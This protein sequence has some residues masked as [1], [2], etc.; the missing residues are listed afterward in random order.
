M[1]PIDRLAPSTHWR[2][3]S[4]V[5][6]NTIW[7]QIDW[8]PVIRRMFRNSYCRRTNNNPRRLVRNIISSDLF[9]KI[10]SMDFV[11][12][13]CWPPRKSWVYSIL[14][15]CM[16]HASI[17]NKYEFFNRNWKI[18]SGEV[19]AD[20]F[21]KCSTIRVGCDFPGDGRPG[22]FKL[23]PKNTLIRWFSK[24]FLPF[25]RYE[26]ASAISCH[27]HWTCEIFALM[28]KMHWM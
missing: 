22:I 23:S 16:Y 2:S 13:A 3:Y 15:I 19:E 26:N 5:T 20:V 17:I 25:V 12:Q 10:I 1:F 14:L 9:E 27:N 28:S 4:F 24:K 21:I 6:Q 18:I 11:S 8:C 7:I